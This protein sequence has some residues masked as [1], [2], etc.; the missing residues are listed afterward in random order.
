MNGNNE[1]EFI[2]HK[3]LARLNGLMEDHILANIVKI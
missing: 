1:F 2:I 3:E